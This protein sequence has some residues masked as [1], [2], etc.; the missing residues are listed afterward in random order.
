MQTN[1]G[2][3]MLCKHFNININKLKKYLYLLYIYQIFL[4]KINGQVTKCEY[5]TW[6]TICVPLLTF[7]T[8]QIHVCLALFPLCIISDWKYLSDRSVNKTLNSLIRDQYDCFVIQ[9]RS[10]QNYLSHLFS[11]FLT[12]PHKTCWQTSVF[13]NCIGSIDSL[14]CDIWGDL[15]SI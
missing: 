1:I 15:S 11:P 4:W 3:F 9:E 5:R 13:V 14:P 10:L 2:E 7:K 6:T 12:C 8:K